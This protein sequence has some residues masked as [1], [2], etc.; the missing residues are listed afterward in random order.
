MKKFYKNERG[1]LV[2]EFMFMLPALMLC[3]LGMFVFFDAFHKWMKFTTAS[4]TISDLLSRQTI[5]DDDFILSL[6]GVFDTISGSRDRENSWLR[7]TSVKKS[8]GNLTI[9]WSI[10]T[11]DFPQTTPVAV[12][13]EDLIPNSTI[14]E[15]MLLVQSYSPYSPGFSW[16][17]LNGITLRENIAIS[18][19]FS[20]KLVN[21]D[22]LEFDESTDDGIDDPLAL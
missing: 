17:G 7:V 13:I 9:L 21:S 20:S 14:D 19:R 8:G 6:D 15:H 16:V 18:S 22:H 10:E 1:V 12:D 5:V 11:S 2:T 3:F 4:Y